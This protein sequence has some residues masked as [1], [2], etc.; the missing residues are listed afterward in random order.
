MTVARRIRPA[1]AP[2]VSL[3]HTAVSV[4]APAGVAA[5]HLDLARSG[6]R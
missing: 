6:V 1:Q 5:R 3:S 2:K 4:W